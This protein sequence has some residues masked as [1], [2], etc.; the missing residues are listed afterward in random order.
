MTLLTSYNINKCSKVSKN[1]LWKEEVISVIYYNN[2][3]Q[4]ITI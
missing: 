3:E 1:G 4:F 2:A